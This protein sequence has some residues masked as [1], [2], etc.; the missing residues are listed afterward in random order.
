MHAV[1]S[2]QVLDS[3]WEKR[4]KMTW[5]GALPAHFFSALFFNESAWARAA[6]LTILR[7]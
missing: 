3:L 7:S 6:I 4:S 1:S 2:M 5:E